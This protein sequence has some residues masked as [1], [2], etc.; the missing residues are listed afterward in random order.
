MNKRK[1]GQNHGVSHG[2]GGPRESRSGSATPWRARANAL[3]EIPPLPPWQSK[4]AIKSYFDC[5]C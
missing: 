5:P 4:V 2:R 1:E 3:A